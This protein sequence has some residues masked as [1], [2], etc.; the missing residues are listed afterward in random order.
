[1]TGISQAY[2]T[3]HG[4]LYLPRGD[5]WI[6]RSFQT[7]Q[8]WEENILNAMLA[9]LPDQGGVYVD[10]GSFVGTH[11]IPM[12]KKAAKV[13][14]FEPQR[15][16]FQMLCANAVVN[17]VTNLYPFNMALGHMHCSAISM[18][19]TVPDGVSKGKKLQ[20]GSDVP[21]NFGGTNIGAGGDIA[22]M[23]TLDSVFNRLDQTIQG[24]DVLKVDV[25]GAEPLMFHGAR[26][27][28]AKYKPS[29]FYEIDPRFDITPEMHDQMPIKPDVASFNIEDYAKLLGY[30]PPVQ[31]GPCDW[32]LARP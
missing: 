4:L 15:H 20:F 19:G 17:D 29:I 8:Y 5:E 18:N 6:G 22:E 21:I 26:Q 13:L 30:G 1:M 23:H 10:A 24:C 3:K 2:Y 9:K 7:G 31:L 25:Q 28:I 12:S 27:T 11:V 16:I 32:L 14:A